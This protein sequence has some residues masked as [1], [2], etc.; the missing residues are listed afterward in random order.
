MSFLRHDP[1]P[2]IICG[3]AHASCKAG[4]GAIVIDQLSS[5]AAGP[6]TI[7]PHLS[8]D[9][10]ANA[11]VPLELEAERVQAT[12]PAGTFTSGTYRRPKKSRTTIG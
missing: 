12:L 2:C 11:T 3:A 10:A 8:R 1:G 5:P 4:D 6:I 9:A 7:P